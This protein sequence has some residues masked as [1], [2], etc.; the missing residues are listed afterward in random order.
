MVLFFILFE[1]FL[2]FPKQNKPCCQPVTIKKGSDNRNKTNAA[3]LWL[4]KGPW[5]SVDKPCPT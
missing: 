5:K 4:S 1:S 2:Y 3:M